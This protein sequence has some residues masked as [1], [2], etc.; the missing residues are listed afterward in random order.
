MGTLDMAHALLL[1]G[2]TGAGKTPLG[3]F[4]MQQGYHGKRCTHFDFGAALRAVEATG[5][6]V[7]SLTQKDVTFIHQVLT[8]GALLEDE[9]FYIAAELLRAHIAA[10]TLG[11]DDYV[12]LN[13]LPRHIG[14]ANNIDDI[15]HITHVLS[16]HCSPTV[17][18]Q[19]IN[20]NSGGDRSA[21]TD[22]APEA[23]IRKL[24]IF[25]SRTQPLI[26]H[27]RTRGTRVTEVDITTDTAPADLWT[28]F[29]QALAKHP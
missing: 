29:E 28:Q 10:N 14:Q 7:G 24:E 13:G 5:K 22:D 1:I 21:R 27:Y 18:R 20:N 19:R 6:P 2:P 12:L 16:L 9:T 23:V 26:D 3:E 25:N 15:I 11:P 17:V 8:E 4:A